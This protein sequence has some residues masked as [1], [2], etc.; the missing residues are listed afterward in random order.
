MF[1]AK[2]ASEGQPITL[3]QLDNK[4]AFL[5][6]RYFEKVAKNNTVFNA[7]VHHLTSGQRSKLDLLINVRFGAKQT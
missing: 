5:A 2:R 3:G 1:F 6:D 4:G 7:C